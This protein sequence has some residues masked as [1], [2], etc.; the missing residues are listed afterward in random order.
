MKLIYRMETL[1]KE[2]TKY[3]VSEQK[4]NVNILQI[5]LIINSEYA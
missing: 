3:V 2:A 1:F 5:Y 4:S